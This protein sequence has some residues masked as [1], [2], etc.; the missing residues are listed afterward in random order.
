MLGET[1][2]KDIIYQLNINR[3]ISIERKRYEYKKFVKALSR[4]HS[5]IML[6]PE[7]RKT[8]YK[9]RLQEKILLKKI[10]SVIETFPKE[11]TDKIIIII[12][13]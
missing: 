8:E 2:V 6:S 4:V 5:K 13:N 11:N 12:E 3:G 1:D 7:G 10:N 9:E